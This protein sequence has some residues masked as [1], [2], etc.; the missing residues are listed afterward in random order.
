[1]R[2][3][4]YFVGVVSE[5]SQIVATQSGKS[6]T[7]FRVESKGAKDQY[8]NR[9]KCLAYADRVGPIKKGQIV[10]VSG[11]LNA[12]AYMGKN[13]NQP[14]GALKMFCVTVELHGEAPAPAVANAPK[15]GADEDQI[16]F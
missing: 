15:A 8:P 11:D 3:Q 12:E 13:D 10:A 1:M 5:D 16:P 6:F 4:G 14:K 2:V 9:L 7:A